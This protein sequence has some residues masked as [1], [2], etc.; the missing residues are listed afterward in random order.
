MKKFYREISLKD[1]LLTLINKW[2]IIALFVTFSVGFT[3]WAN[4]TYFVPL[5]SAQ[6]TLFFGND[7]SDEESMS[8]NDFRIGLE[9]INDYREL[10][11]S[12]LVIEKVFDHLNYDM[13]LLDVRENLTINSV[14]G[15]RF[16]YITYTDTSPE[17]AMRVANKFSDELI[18][19]AEGMVGF[20]KITIFDY[21][22]KPI[23]PINASLIID[24]IIAVLAGGVAGVFFIF[25]IMFFD[26]RLKTEKDIENIFGL[27]V[28]GNIPIE[29]RQKSKERI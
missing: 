8:L 21:A 28:I 19:G 22:Q 3:Y 11:Q 27:P 4:L 1:L 23:Q 14:K 17:R 7:P 20:N 29:H 24:L 16:M 13:N 5:Y 15:T 25:I 10:V 18:I 12:R 2:W 9:L 26:T 6:S